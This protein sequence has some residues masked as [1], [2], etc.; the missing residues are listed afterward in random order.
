MLIELI[1]N[2]IFQI[3]LFLIIPLVVY[4]LFYRKTFTF[5]A[6]L[7]IKP[8]TKANQKTLIKLSIICVIY[9]ILGTYSLGKYTTEFED[10]RKLAFNKY[11]FSL[12]TVLIFIIQSI[13]RTA[14]LEEMVFRGFLLN[15]LKSHLK[16][17][18]A[19]I[20]QALIFAAIHILGMLQ[21]QLF[22]IVLIS[23]FIFLVAYYFGK[24]TKE[25]GD[26]IFYSACFH[27]AMNILAGIMFI[28]LI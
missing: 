13:I 17:E 26:S 9:I 22:D 27:S 8:Q 18:I 6:F 28:Y 21:F 16:F 19:N 12:S 11:G 15:V 5:K 10:I 4:L 20:V 25:S 2:T 1:K 3:I 24:L 7:G 23:V 14:V